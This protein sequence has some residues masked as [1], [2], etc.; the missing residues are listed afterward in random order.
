MDKKIRTFKEYKEEKLTELER[1]VLELKSEQNCSFVE[2]RKKIVSLDQ[3][4]K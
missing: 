2:E 4:K 3:K 1:H